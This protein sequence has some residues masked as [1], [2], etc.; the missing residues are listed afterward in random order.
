MKRCLIILIALICSIPTARAGMKVS[1]T[2]DIVY[3]HRD[4]LALVFDV[5]RPENRTGPPF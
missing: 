4:G 5:I 1:R 3:D 2:S